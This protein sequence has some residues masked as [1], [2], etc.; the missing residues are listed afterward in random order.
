MHKQLHF[1]LMMALAAGTATSA[2][3]QNAAPAIGLASSGR[4]S[5]ASIPD[6]SGIWGHPYFPG[7]E[8]PAS[9]PS[10]VTN[11]SRL[12]NGASNPRQLVGDYSNP[13]L[14]PQ[15]AEVVKRHGEIELSSGAPNPHNQC[16]PQAVPFLLYNYGT[17]MLQQPHQITILYSQDHEVRHVRMNQPHLAPAAPSWH[18]DSVGHYEGDTLVIDTIGVKN[19]GMVSDHNSW[20]TP[21]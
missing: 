3:G 18:G 9:G 12:P 7:F 2:W 11:K 20:S 14:K 8:P 15:A 16:W 1:V 5:A 4:P 19:N 17:Q 13:I 6:F 10:P 21:G